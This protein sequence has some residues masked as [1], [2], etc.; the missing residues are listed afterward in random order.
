MELASK[1]GIFLLSC[2]RP[3][4]MQAWPQVF[5]RQAAF[6]IGF[7]RRFSLNAHFDKLFLV[8]KTH[9]SRPF[10]RPPKTSC[11]RP[12]PTFNQLRFAVTEGGGVAE[13]ANARGTIIDAGSVAAKL[14]EQVIG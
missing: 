14:E 7:P 3:T 2:P 1:L 10:M 5:G 4:C 11:H 13:A 8:S 9:S 12:Y 6:T